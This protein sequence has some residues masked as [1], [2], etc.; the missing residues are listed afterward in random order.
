M[1]KQVENFERQIMEESSMK[2]SAVTAWAV[3]ISVATLGAI[4][5][6]CAFGGKAS[7]KEEVLLHDGKK[8]ILE[9]S[10]TR[11]GRHEIGQDIPVNRHTISFAIPGTGRTVT[12]DSEFGLEIERPSLLPLALDVV[13]GIPYL[14]TT[15]AGC[16]AYNKWGRP[17]PPYIFFK[18]DGKAWQRI[19]LAEFPAEI[20]EA[21]MVIGAL[22]LRDE[23]R[24]T[25]YSGPVPAE[26]V[27]KMNA[28]ARNP[29][30]LYLR[31]FAR[32]PIKVGATTDCA[33]MV[34]DG[35]GGWIGTGWFRDQPSYEAC[36]QYC[37]RHKIAIQHCPCGHF[38]KGGK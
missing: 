26:E 13:G 9:R 3:T 35:N 22:T 8:I 4:M 36:L 15:T 14:V 21:N 28:E 23:R 30:V 11:G 34:Y 33:E 31:M 16:I 1:R 19:P 7:W 32:D 37:T 25:G 24:L 38:F 27:R 5:N 6:A 2:K 12:W 17:N 18:F 10:Q 29:Q 20:K